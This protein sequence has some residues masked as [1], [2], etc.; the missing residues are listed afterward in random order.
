V[1]EISH[2]NKNG[3]PKRKYVR[4]PKWGGSNYKLTPSFIRNV[5]RLAALGLNQRQI[6]TVLNVGESTLSIWK[7]SDGKLEEKFQ[8]ALAR[9]EAEGI[10]RR[11]ARIEKA[12]RNGTW[13]ADTWILERL[14]SGQ[15]SRRDSMKISDPNGNPVAGTTVIAPTVV[16]VQPKKEEL[17]GAIGTLEITNGN[18]VDPTP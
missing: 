12:G 1:S 4:K 16:F 8:K 9:G 18:G 3:K 6:A 5:E 7:S 15:F 11:L 14:Q 2:L 10:R 17:A 13:Q